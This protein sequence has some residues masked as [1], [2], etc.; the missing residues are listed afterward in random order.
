MKALK[1][2]LLASL[3]ISFS[4]YAADAPKYIFYMI[5]DG[6]AASQRQVAEYYLQEVSHNPAAKLAIDSLPV[7]G[8]ITTYSSSSLVTD[9]AARSIQKGKKAA[10]C[11]AARSRLAGSWGGGANARKRADA[12]ATYAEFRVY[13]A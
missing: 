12:Q 3:V 7:A 13:P 8:I 6:M 9:S 1:L 5:G 4:S 11:A 10:P 2:A